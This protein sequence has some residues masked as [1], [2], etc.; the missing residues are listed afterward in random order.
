[1]DKLTSM[2]VFTQ[3]A[4]AK[5]FAGAAEQLGMSRAMVSK[6]V[7]R[8][9]NSLGVRLLNR[10]TRRLLREPFLFVLNVRFWPKAA[11]H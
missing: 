4:K 11:V 3:I 5:T 9:E 2:K 1:M 7:L 10:T 8:L 6:H